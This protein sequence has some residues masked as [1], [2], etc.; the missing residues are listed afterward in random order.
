MTSGALLPL[1]PLWGKWIALLRETKGAATGRRRAPFPAFGRTSPK[2]GREC[3]L[4]R[5]M[6]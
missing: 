1:C 4:I 2:G 3:Q 6:P 5:S